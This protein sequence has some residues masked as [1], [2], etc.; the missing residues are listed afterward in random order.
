MDILVVGATG[1]VG[2]AVLTPDEAVTVWG[3]FGAFILA[4]SSRCRAPRT[5]LELG[6]TPRHTDMLTMIGEPRLRELAVP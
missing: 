5:R 6:W 3:E 1:F 4:A 2:G